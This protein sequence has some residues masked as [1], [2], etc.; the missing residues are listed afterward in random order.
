[1]SRK[2]NCMLSYSRFELLREV[3]ACPLVPVAV[4]C[5]RYSVGYS[6]SVTLAMP[7]SSRTVGATLLAVKRRSPERVPTAAEDSRSVPGCCTG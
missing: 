4:G 7:S 3:H 2:P 6:P 5:D 1:M